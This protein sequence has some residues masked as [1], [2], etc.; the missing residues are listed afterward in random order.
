MPA[1]DKRPFRT[2]RTGTEHFTITEAHPYH[3]PV[4]K[5]DHKGAGVQYPRTFSTDLINLMCQRQ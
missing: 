5:V 4:G 1:D 3:R 2:W